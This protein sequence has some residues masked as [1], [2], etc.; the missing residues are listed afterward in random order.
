[1]SSDKT[2]PLNRRAFLGAAATGA[3]AT[4]LGSGG[5][6]PVLAQ[7]GDERTRARYRVTEHIEHFYRTNRYTRPQE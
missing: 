4:A 2:T 7:A 6:T 5:A 3:A 1:M